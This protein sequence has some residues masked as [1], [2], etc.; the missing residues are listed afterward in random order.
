MGGALHAAGV[1]RVSAHETAAVIMTV[2]YAGSERTTR[3]RVERGLSVL[4][5][6]AHA[7]RRTCWR[8]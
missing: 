5:S 6:H 3:M 1:A 7:W 4:D 8:A 2:W